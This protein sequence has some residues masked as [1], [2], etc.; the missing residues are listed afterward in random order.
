[1]TKKNY[2]EVL[3]VKKEASGDEI[4]K[5][6][7]RLAM[8]FHPDRNQ[9]NKEAE[10]KFKKIQEA[11]AVLSDEKKRSLYDQLGHEN[12]ESAVKGGGAQGFSGGFSGFENVGDIFGDIFGNIFNEARR[13][14]GGARHASRGQDLLVGLKITLEESVF[15]TN[16]IVNIQHMI[17]CHGC[18]GSGAQKGSKPEKCK[19]CNGS[20]QVHMQQGFFAIQQTC[21]VCHG[22]GEIIANPCLDCH[23]RGQVKISKKLS[24]KVPAGIDNGDRIR[25]GGEGNAGLHGAS[26][27]DL[28]VEITILPHKIFR[29]NG[30]DLHCELPIT[31]TSA[32]LGNEYEM[33][34]LEGKVKLK[35]PPET[36]SGKVMRL[37]GKGIKGIRG[38]L[39]DL[40][41]TINIETPVNLDNEQKELLR[42]FDDLLAKDRKK[43][44]PISRSWFSGVKDFF[45]K[46]A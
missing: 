16:G 22:A 31:F 25:L 13:G 7:R 37:S 30:L 17:N 9:N 40:Y 5:A 14:G 24:V 23:S 21:P 18:N 19:H 4:K 27:G 43:H 38:G 39:G 2:Y 35:V 1:M 8:K 28:Y 33:P 6:Y 42:R 20:G 44:S 10:N 12:F 36:Q 3:G 34:T 11:Y 15:G 41:C 29:R 46:F 32:A 45:A 26:A